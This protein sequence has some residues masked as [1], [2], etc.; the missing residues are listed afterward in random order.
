[1]NVRSGPGSPPQHDGDH[2]R[3]PSGPIGGDGFGEPPSDDL[4]RRVPREPGAP[5]LPGET[6][7]DSDLVEALR[8]RAQATLERARVEVVATGHDPDRA[9]LDLKTRNV[10]LLDRP[11]VFPDA[12][13]TG[14]VIPRAQLALAG[15]R[16][17][18]AP[19]RATQPRAR[20]PHRQT[21]RRGP[22]ST[23][24][25]DDD[26][27]EP[28]PAGGRHDGL[29]QLGKSRPWADELLRL[30]EIAP[31]PYAEQLYALVRSAA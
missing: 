29:E 24:S 28:A 14:R 22:P 21:R 11:A 23:S 7:E 31:E 6:D 4:L 5:L 30:V 18:G 3:D 26:P 13:P 25:S 2:D 12:Q 1:M 27:D 19:Q 10:V 15:Q 20:E 16:V 8:D 9:V 17:R